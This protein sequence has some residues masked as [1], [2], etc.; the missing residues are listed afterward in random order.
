MN[1][2]HALLALTLLA[3]SGLGRAVALPG[4]VVTP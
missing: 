4:P 3:A 2:L 1:R